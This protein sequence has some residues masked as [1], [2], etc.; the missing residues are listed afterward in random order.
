MQY[1]HNVLN[2]FAVRL[3]VAWHSGNAL[4]PS[5]K[6]TICWAWLCV[7]VSVTVCRHVSHLVHKQSARSAQPFTL[8]GRMSIGL[9][10]SMLISNKWWRRVYYFSYRFGWIWGWGWLTCS[11]G[12]QPLGTHARWIRWTCSHDGSAMKTASQTLFLAVILTTNVVVLLLLLS[13]CEVLRCLPDS[14]RRDPGSDGVVMATNDAWWE[15]CSAAFFGFSCSR[16]W[17][18]LWYVRPIH[19]TSQLLVIPRITYPLVLVLFVSLLR[20]F[21]TP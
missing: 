18:A 8:Y 16:F 2:V 1:V 5:S 15:R 12:C 10:F 9:Q 7:P 4:C 19:S 17:V 3:L 6:V 14:V 21:G 13:V 20:E 11:K